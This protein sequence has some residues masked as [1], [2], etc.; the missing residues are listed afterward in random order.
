MNSIGGNKRWNCLEI[1]K[2]YNMK[3]AQSWYARRPITLFTQKTWIFNSG[4]NEKRLNSVVVRM[5]MRMKRDYVFNA[6]RRPIHSNKM[7]TGTFRRAGAAILGI[8][9]IW[10]RTFRNCERAIRF[11]WR[12][13]VLGRKDSFFNK[14][15]EKKRRVKNILSRVRIT[16]ASR[17]E[18]RSVKNALRFFFGTDSLPTVVAVF[19]FRATRC[20]EDYLE[21]A[22]KSISTTDDF[23]REGPH[24][25]RMSDPFRVDYHAINRGFATF[26]AAR[27]SRFAWNKMSFSLSIILI[28]SIENVSPESKRRSV[29]MTRY[30]KGINTVNENDNK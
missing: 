2:L 4:C 3:R 21:S 27:S 20:K 18:F 19:L 23:H 9:D 22:P 25:A 1:L 10:K 15:N 13:A 30:Q 28:I 26:R 6:K 7:R 8:K 5:I 16:R 17:G 11:H 14:K 24:L 12:H 29:R